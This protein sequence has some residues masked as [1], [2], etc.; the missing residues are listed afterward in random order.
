MKNYCIVYP[1][2]KSLTAIWYNLYLYLVWFVVILVCLDQEKSGN[3]GPRCALENKCGLTFCTL[4]AIHNFASTL[5]Q[6][7]ST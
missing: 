2:L 7:A 5:L 1:H 6:L 3:P 4:S